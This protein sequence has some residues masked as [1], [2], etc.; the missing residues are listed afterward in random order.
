ME[1]WKE[2]EKTLLMGTVEGGVVGVVSV[3]G[4]L[5]I[6]RDLYASHRRHTS[7]PCNAEGF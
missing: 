5:Q 1:L 7:L 3:G 6:S 2:S 4:K